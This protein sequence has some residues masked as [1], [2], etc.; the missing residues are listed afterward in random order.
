MNVAKLRISLLDERFKYEAE[1]IEDSDGRYY[2]VG[3]TAIEITKNEYERVIANPR[4][5]YFSIALRLH[6]VI[7]KSLCKNVRLPEL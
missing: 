4:L 2:R 6:N 7:E 3:D 1:A 5:Y